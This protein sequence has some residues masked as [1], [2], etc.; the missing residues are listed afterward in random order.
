MKDSLLA[1]L[2]AASIALLS[3]IA[4]TGI[5]AVRGANRINQEIAT[6]GALFQASERTL[7]RLTSDLDAARVSVRD[8]II[9]PALAID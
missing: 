1:V 6:S 9:D 2:A 7:S 3:I 4:L 5:G 8:Y